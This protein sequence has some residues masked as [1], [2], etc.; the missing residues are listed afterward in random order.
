M[1]TNIYLFVASAGLFISVCQRQR[2]CGHPGHLGPSLA[3]PCPRPEAPCQ[4]RGSPPGQGDATVG[5]ALQ[6]CGALWPETDWV[7]S[8][9]SL[10][11]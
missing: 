1:M 2:M 3:I 6:E 7:S 11:H 10:S 4:A 8:V 9:L 5:S